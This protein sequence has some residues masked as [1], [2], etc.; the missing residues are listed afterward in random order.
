MEL[1]YIHPTLKSRLLA[2]LEIAGPALLGCGLWISGVLY[3]AVR[4]PSCGLGVI[5]GPLGLCGVLLGLSF[6]SLRKGIRTLRSGQSPPPGTA[7]L[8][9]RRVATGWRAKIDGFSLLGLS[10]VFLYMLT[11]WVAPLVSSGLALSVP[12]VPDCAP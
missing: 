2:V 5:A 7:V 1:S 6:F 11:F 8:F 9:K 10:L 3:E 12:V 4:A